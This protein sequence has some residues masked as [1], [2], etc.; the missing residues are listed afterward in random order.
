MAPMQP[1][2]F[3]STTTVG[4]PSSS[5]RRAGA[6]NRRVWI[7]ALPTKELSLST[8]FRAAS[9]NLAHGGATFHLPEGV[10]SMS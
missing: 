3:V 4:G 7:H 10:E 2:A 5:R 9:K 6:E 8:A 1:G